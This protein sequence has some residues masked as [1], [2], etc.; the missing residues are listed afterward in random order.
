[1]AAFPRQLACTAMKNKITMSWKQ[2]D[3]NDRLAGDHQDWKSATIISGCCLDCQ[4][5]WTMAQNTSVKRI[6]SETK[7]SLISQLL[8]AEVNP[9][10][11]DKDMFYFLLKTR[12]AKQHH[13]IPHNTVWHNGHQST[14]MAR[15]YSMV[16]LTGVAVHVF[17]LHSRCTMSPLTSWV[18]VSPGPLLTTTPAVADWSW[19]GLQ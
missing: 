7:F 2:E 5:I 3:H 11:C 15:N 16:C 13:Q 9:E 14:E 1:M 17:L 10:I 19:D 12:T 4:S 8:Q 6:I 18:P